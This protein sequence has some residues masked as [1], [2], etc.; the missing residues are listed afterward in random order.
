MVKHSPKP[1]VPHYAKM[2][3]QPV[4]FAN[5]F[6][7]TSNI[8]NVIKY[9]CRFDSKNGYEDILKAIDYLDWLQDEIENDMVSNKQTVMDIVARKPESFIFL[10]SFVQQKE[11]QRV[12]G[13]ILNVLALESVNKEYNVNWKEKYLKSSKAIYSNIILQIDELTKEIYGKSILLENRH[14]IEK[15]KKFNR[16]PVKYNISYNDEPLND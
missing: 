16:T 2:Q 8:M 5:Y 13:I 4:D 14:P 6:M 12:S 3:I 15:Y 1:N 7:T 11:I 9:I 10:N